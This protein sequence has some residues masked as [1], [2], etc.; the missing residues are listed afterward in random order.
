MRNP[1]RE[2]QKFGQ[3]IWYD[4]IRRGLITSGELVSMINGDG[5]LGI[6]SNP[7]IF[8]KA[9]AGS[10]DYDP[11]MK[12]LVTKGVKDAQQLFEQLAIQD[13]QLA[14]DVL[15]PTYLGTSAL[16][17]YV[18]LEVSPYLANDTEATVAEARRLWAEVGRSNV[19]IKVPATPEGIPAIRTLIGEGINVNV[20][21]IFAV[22]AYETVV[23]A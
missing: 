17:G 14:A 7:A 16:D 20:T 8:E 4:N 11:A 3:S 10:A 6:T 23:E 13:I 21:L 1:I 22:E 19:M 18:S 15:H 5:I 2:V 9:L 12:A